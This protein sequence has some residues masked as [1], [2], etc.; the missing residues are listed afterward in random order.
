VQVN[1]AGIKRD[2]LSIKMK[3]SDFA[4]VIN[5]NLNGVFNSTQA[6]IQTSMLKNKRGRVINIA[7]VAGQLGSA[8]QVNYAASK[9]GVIG[10]TKSFAREFA[11]RNICV[12]AVCPGFITTDMTVNLLDENSIVSSIPMRRMGTPEEVSGL[13]LYLA[14]DPSAAYITG[15]C[16]NID[17]GLGIGAT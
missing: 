17:G 14:T 11:S 10:L 3:H 13:V 5:V 12:N 7:S 16:F 15:H 1:N 9:A 6:A 8:G 2:M 4:D